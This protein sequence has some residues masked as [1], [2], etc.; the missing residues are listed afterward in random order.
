MKC[1]M[2]VLDH[3]GHLSVEW[4]P[5]N[6]AEVAG[7]R[8]E[9]ERLRSLGYSFFLTSGERADEVAAGRGKLSV[10]RVDDPIAA[11][12]PPEPP[13]APEPDTI[14]LAAPRRRGRPP[15][16]ETEAIAVRPMRGG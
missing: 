9:V 4:D 6:E 13:E 8:E 10:R 3:S 12:A 2:A 11:M 14:G 15:K 5:N 16:A 7:A 1:R